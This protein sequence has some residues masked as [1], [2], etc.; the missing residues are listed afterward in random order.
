MAKY[1]EIFTNDDDD[2]YGGGQMTV[3]VEDGTEVL[4]DVVAIFPYNDKEYIALTP[5][6]AAEDA[7]D[8]DV[9][10]YQFVKNGGE[11][12]LLDIDDESEIE[13]I[14]DAFY[15]YLDTEEYDGEF[16]DE[17]DMYDEDG[18]EDDMYDDDDEE[19]SMF[20]EYDDEE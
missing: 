3:T 11:V 1:S 16:G 20:D 15:E 2:E 19:A 6:D 5:A 18:G 8:A 13:S 9:Y 10:L 17:D 4:C 7:E 12:E 14:E